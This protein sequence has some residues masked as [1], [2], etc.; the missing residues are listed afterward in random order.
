MSVY[1]I[2]GKKLGNTIQNAAGINCAVN[3]VSIFSVSTKKIYTSAALCRLFYGGCKMITKKELNM[4][5]GKFKKWQYK[6]FWDKTERGWAEA[7][8]IY[9]DEAAEFVAYCAGYLIRKEK[10]GSSK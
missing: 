2:T 1:N 3:G 8:G 9:R 10:D 6:E 7:Y 5:L 4:L